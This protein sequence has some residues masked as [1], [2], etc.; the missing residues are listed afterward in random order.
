MTRRNVLREVAEQLE[1]AAEGDP[2]F[3][4]GLREELGRVRM[5]RG[6]RQDQASQTEGPITD[7]GVQVAPR[8]EE[9]AAQTGQT[10]DDSCSPSSSDGSE[11]R[12]APA[13][14]DP[15]PPDGCWNC[16]G[17]DHFYSECP[18]PRP[19]PFCYRCGRQGMTVKDCVVC[20]EAW[21]AQ[22]PYRPGHGH[23]GPEP[24]RRQGH[25]PPRGRAARPTP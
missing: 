2:L 23:E 12:G 22:G 24:P 8:T 9:R 13:L 16:G 7:V 21:L 15:T 11:E 10:T 1:L 5:A 18:R 3:W 6:A 17:R 20:R 4:T 14:T 25:P 19:I